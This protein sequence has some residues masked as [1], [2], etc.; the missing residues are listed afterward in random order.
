MS[1]PSKQTLPAEAFSRPETAE[2]AVVLPA[3]LA[4][5]RATISP[6]LTCIDMPWSA[7]RLPYDA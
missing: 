6:R 5:S 2:M 4:P 3:P 7:S 1:F